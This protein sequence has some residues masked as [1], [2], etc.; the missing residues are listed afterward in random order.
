MI[1]PR[2]GVLQTL[3]ADRVFR[4]PHYQRFYSWKKRQREDLFND[5]KTLARDKQR[6]D[7]HHFMATIVCHRTAETKDIGAAQYRV[8]DV[9]DGQQ[10]LTTLILLLKSIELA[11]PEK[12]EDRAEL[13]KTL[14]KRDGHLI[15]LQTNNAN[16]FNF[17]RFIREGVAPSEAEIVLHSDRNLADAIREC[18]EFVKLWTAFHDTLSLMRLVLHRLGFVVFDTEDSR[19]VY[20]IFEVLNSRG[21][22]VDWLDKTKSVLMG[23]AYERSASPAAA[24]AEIH[25]LQGIWAAMYNELAKEDVPGDE[26]LRITA[27]LYYGPGQGKPRSAE[28]SL[29]L[30]RE[31]C[32]SFDKPRQISTQLL[33][34]ARKLVQLYASPH[35]GPVTEI[36]HA[37]LLAV[38]INCAT[39]VTDPERKKL[40]DQW[41]RVTF[42]IFALYGKDSRTKVGDYVRLAAKIVTEDIDTRTYN[43]I[44]SS[45]REL[46]RDYPIEQA[47]EVGVMGKDCYARPEECRYMLWS[48]EEYLAQALGTSATLDENERMQIWKR[49]A[50]DSIEHILPRNAL[51]TEWEAKLI[52]QPLEPNVDR[53]GNLLL[54][55]LVLNQEAQRL[56]FDSNDKARDTKKKIYAQHNLRMVREV[57]EH[58]D[59][60]LSEIV[61]REQRIVQWAKA[62]WCDL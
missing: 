33:D 49:R 42:R 7:Q 32:D 26:I 19:V 51:G 5:I 3:F 20:T 38:A 25:A 13:A 29:D 57:C 36:L 18:R 62:R 39:G 17:N 6:L 9:V 27:T 30:L 16:E 47:L 35:L 55:P 43:Q 15:L 12:S 59:W 53:I 8:Y 1:E 23:R 28:E 22:A 44:M 46:G 52:G 11:L 50:I 21:L 10:R 48:Y 40:L 45:L 24:Q 61:D 14:V 31:A 54:L 60:T 37:G 41:E 56:P 34:V 4:I 2:Y 58:S